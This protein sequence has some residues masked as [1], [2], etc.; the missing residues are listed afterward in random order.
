MKS[1]DYVE[2][3]NK[4]VKSYNEMFHEEMEYKTQD[5]RGYS[6]RPDILIHGS[7]CQSFSTVGQLGGG[8]KVVVQN[9]HLC[10]KL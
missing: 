9:H 2:V 10:G 7:P 4:A 6:L 3:D 5:V 1:I 8:M